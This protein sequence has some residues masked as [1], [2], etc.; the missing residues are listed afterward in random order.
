MGPVWLRLAARQ[1]TKVIIRAASDRVDC[2]CT[3]F[4]EVL[5]ESA[6]SIPD[7]VHSGR[8]VSQRM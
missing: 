8:G 3:L 4:S 6:N 2:L 1:V 5:Y 7:S